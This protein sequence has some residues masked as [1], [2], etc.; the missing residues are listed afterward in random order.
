M[1]RHSIID[2]EESGKT[3]VAMDGRLPIPDQ[4]DAF[5]H[6]R[7]NIDAIR[8]S[9]IRSNNA[10]P[11]HLAHTHDS[12][13]DSLRYIGFEHHHLLCLVQKALW[14]MERPAVDRDVHSAGHHLVKFRHDVRFGF[15]VD[16]LGA[17][18]VVCKGKARGDGI[19]TDDALG[20]L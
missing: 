16:C 15:E 2:I 12:L 9:R 4:T 19:D 5:L 10:N 20:A 13:I 17:R 3:H 8:I 6:K 18:L 14:F 11:S 7:T 1:K